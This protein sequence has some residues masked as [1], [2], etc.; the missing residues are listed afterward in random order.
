MPINLRTGLPGHGKTS[1]TVL[2]V[3][4]RAESEKRTVYYSG[5]KD[6]MVPGWVELSSAADWPSVPDGSIVLIDEAQTLY[7]PRQHGSAVPPYVSALETH[8]HR[9]LD[10]YFITQHPMLIDNNVR[11]LVDEHRHVVRQF[12]SHY[13]REF[14]WPKVNEH[15]DKS[16]ANATVRETQLPKAAFG[17][18]K[19]AELHTIKRRIPWWVYA[20]FLAPVLVGLAWW[21]VVAN[22]KLGADLPGPAAVASAPGDSFGIARPP[23]RAASGVVSTADYLLAHVPR[24]DGLAYTAPV[25]DGVTSVSVAP[26]PAACL[27]MGGDCRCYTQQATR[28]DVPSALC[29]SIVERGFFVAWSEAVPRSQPQVE[30]PAKSSLALPR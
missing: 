16:K 17:L 5:I 7:R 22:F 28:L 27:V 3:M 21:N 14:S 25:Y 1:S 9:G 13:V 8:R 12:G 4:R 30:T 10:L 23:G 2:D 19:S 24:I 26:Y 29:A 20:A 18:Y 6:C 15:P 11:R